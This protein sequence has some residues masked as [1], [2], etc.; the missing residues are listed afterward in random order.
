MHHPGTSSRLGCCLTIVRAHACA[1]VCVCTRACTRAAQCGHRS[2]TYAS[3]VC[4]LDSVRAAHG[5]PGEPHQKLRPQQMEETWV[6][7]WPSARHT[8]TRGSLLPLQREPTPSDCHPLTHEI[9]QVGS[10]DGGGKR[11]KKTLLSFWNS[12]NVPSTNDILV[13]SVTMAAMLQQVA[14]TH[15]LCYAEKKLC[16]FLLLFWHPGVPPLLVLPLR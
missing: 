2:A 5:A 3:F 7:A 14:Q 1:Y 4:I 8:A 13:S 9:F 6:A 11:K 15:L 16:F 12:Q 10:F